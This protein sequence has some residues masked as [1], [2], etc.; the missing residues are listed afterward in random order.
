MGRT[1][2]LLSRELPVSSDILKYPG[3]LKVSICFFFQ[4]AIGRA[5]GDQRPLTRVYK[6]PTSSH[7]YRADAGTQKR[8]R[9]SLMV[10]P[11]F[12]RDLSH[13]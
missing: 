8:R 5:G 2:L 6:Q 12:N 7:L 11:S 3:L 1:I 10:G 13:I 4:R 9:S